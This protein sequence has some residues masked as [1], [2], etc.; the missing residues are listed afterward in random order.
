M[1]RMALT[2][3]LFA[4][5]LSMLFLAPLVCLAEDKGFYSPVIFI[6]K[7]KNLI[8]ISDSGAVFGIEAGEAAKPH[9]DKLP[10]GTLADFLVEMRANQPPLLKSWKI[11]VG[12]T[13]CKYFDG[14]T[15]R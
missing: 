12:E 13:T 3:T 1:Q 9:L 2:T 14:K 4:L 8:F 15:C 11:P 5:I 6:D 7:E 10:V